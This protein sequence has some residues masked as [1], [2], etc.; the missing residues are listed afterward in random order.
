MVTIGGLLALAATPAMAQ[1]AGSGNLVSTSPSPPTGAS[2]SHQSTTMVSA[3]GGTR[4]VIYGVSG[5]DLAPGVNKSNLLV[6]PQPVASNT[7][8]RS[9]AAY[10]ET[11][12]NQGTVTQNPTVRVAVSNG[13]G[14]GPT[15][16]F[17]SVDVHVPSSVSNAAGGAS[18]A[19]N[20]TGSAGNL[21]SVGNGA[22]AGTVKSLAGNVTGNLTK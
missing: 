4:G 3:G 20:L 5:G 6:V 13:L 16:T 22:S 9:A 17:R 1:L 8:N 11:G 2:S 10:V 15:S 12:A 7:S 21:S 14:A 19:G 18:G